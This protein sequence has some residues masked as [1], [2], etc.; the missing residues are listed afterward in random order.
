MLSRNK[1]TGIDGL[2]DLWLK[3]N[4]TW[5]L[6]R[7]KVHK[8][9]NQ[10]SEVGKVPKYLKKSRVVS[11]SKDGTPT[12][13]VGNNRTLAI[14]P[15]PT[16]LYEQVILLQLKEDITQLELIHENQRGFQEGRS[17]ADNLIDLTFII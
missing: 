15:I 4:F 2:K 3:D 16:K 17:C 5:L 10:W 11:M 9:F 8:I 12:P 1:A 14:A 13:E 7:F 6:I